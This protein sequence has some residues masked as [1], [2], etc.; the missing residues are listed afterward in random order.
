[1]LASCST[2][3]V[4]RT[5]GRLVFFCVRVLSIRAQRFGCPDESIG[6]VHMRSQYERKG[7]AKG[8][9]KKNP[10]PTLSFF[11]FWAFRGEGVVVD[12]LIPI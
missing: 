3:S 7:I 8:A 2:L 12:I 1:M 5:V 10:G 9:R 6:V 11:L 4:V